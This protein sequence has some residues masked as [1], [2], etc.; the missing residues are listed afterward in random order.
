MVR[1]LLIESPLRCPKCQAT[2]ALLEQLVT[3]RPGQLE[4]QIVDTNSPEAAC[5]DLMLTPATVVGDF[6]VATGKVPRRE[7]LEAYL[8]RLG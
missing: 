6:V 2:R 1:I 3:A 7:R 8:D 5:Y 4:L